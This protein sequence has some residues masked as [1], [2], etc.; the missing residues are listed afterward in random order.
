MFKGS[1][2]AL[3]T[4]FKNNKL[5]ED[6]YISLIH[7]HLKN[8]TSGLV[9]AG[10]T[11]ES[12]TLSHQEHKQVIEECIRIVD[13]RLP[14]IAG[15]GSNAF[16]SGRDQSED[17]TTTEYSGSSE[18]S[19]NELIRTM[20]QLV[21]AMVDGFAI[22]SGN[23]LAYMC[24]FTIASE[25]STFGQTGPRVGSPATGWEIGYLANVVGQKRAREIWMLSQQYSAQKALEMGL[26][27]SVVHHDR[28][29]KEVERYC[30][31]IKN[32]SP[33]ILQL[34][35]LT[36]NEIGD[37]SK[38]NQSPAA[39]FIPDYNQSDEATER[40]LAFLE[41]RP[42]NPSKNLSYVKISPNDRA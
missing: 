40:R 13:G 4:P 29:E 39:Q 34:E 22:G 16:C 30:S 20:P 11:G 42:I 27:N 31:L 35:K 24:D 15:T 36:F 14:V 1:I 19:V 32:N 5:D 6:C 37:Y 21:I 33:V 25:R 8:D 2:V 7:Y 17:P 28:L 9:P 41:R 38:G 3:I 12:P 23:I 10:T 18:L 26:V